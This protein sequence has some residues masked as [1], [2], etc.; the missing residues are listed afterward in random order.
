MFNS[1]K[2]NIETLNVHYNVPMKQYSAAC[3]D[4]PLKKNWSDSWCT[5]PESFDNCLEKILN[6]EVRP[7]DVFVIT[8]MKCGTTWMQETAWLLLNDLNFEKS[9]E[10]RIL[11]R[12]PFLDFVG[13]LPP[14]S[15]TLDPLM[16]TEKLDDPRLIKSHM[17]ANLLPSQIWQKKQKIIYVARNVKDVIVSSYHFAQNGMWKGNS[18]VDYVNTFTSSE[19]HWTPFW[20]HI[21]DFWNMRNEPFIFFVTYEE[22]IKDL[23]GVIQRL[24]Q[25]LNRP[26]LT[27][28]E[29]KRLIAHLSFK[30]MKDNKQ[31]N[32]TEMMKE[33]F[34]DVS[35][36]FEFMRRGIVGSYRDELTPEMQTKINNWTAAILARHGLTEQDIFGEF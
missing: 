9:K 24:C 13:L 14:G 28:E 30:E 18:I 17:P 12:S 4:I 31:A 32:L 22:M 15:T 5:L 16:L 8:F 27:V 7:R 2:L 29:L 10:K 34:P 11:E 23:R 19:I 1:R 33:T 25:F 6:F 3:T 21:L 36:D 35:E 20:T 26:L